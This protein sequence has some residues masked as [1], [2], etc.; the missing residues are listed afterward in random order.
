MARN[1]Q[2]NLAVGQFPSQF[3]KGG[4]AGAVVIRHALPG[5]GTDES[6]LDVHLAH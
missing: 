3:D 4:Q 6:V 5:G 2:S 1:N